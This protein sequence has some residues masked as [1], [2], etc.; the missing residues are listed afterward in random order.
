MAGRRFNM[1]DDDV[2][3]VENG[4][5]G[6]VEDEL[7]GGVADVINEVGM[8]DEVDGGMEES[9][10]SGSDSEDSVRSEMILFGDPDEDVLTDSEPIANEDVET[11]I[12]V[13]ISRR[14]GGGGASV[15][16]V[17]EV[18]GED[19]SVLG[20]GEV[21]GAGNVH[22]MGGDECNDGDVDSNYAPSDEL[23]SLPSD[24]DDEFPRKRELI[25]NRDRDL[26]NPKLVVGTKFA[27]PVDFRELLRRFSVMKGFDL[28]FKKNFGQKITATCKEECG[29]RI[30]SSWTIDKKFF[31]IKTFQPKHQCSR[32]YKNNQASSTWLANY[33]LEKIRDNLDW[34]LKAMRVTIKRELELDVSK[35]KVYRTKREALQMIEGKHLEQYNRLWDYCH[36]IRTTNPCSYVQ[37]KVERFHLSMPAAFQRLFISFVA[38]INGFKAGCRLFIGLDGCFL[39][40]CYGGQLLSAVGRDGNNQMFPL[41]MAVVEAEIKHSWHWFMTNL[42]QALDCQDYTGI[43]FISDRQKGLVDTFAVL[44]PGADHRHCVRHMYANFKEKHKEQDLKDML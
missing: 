11:L 39:K 21:G 6:A 3:N 30:H 26:D 23:I 32:N 29:W 34:K 13:A 42:L 22:N 41:A 9:S 36:A 7:D 27:T 38:Q 10:E 18:D 5:V 25:Y 19:D 16:G 37:M 43:T 44:L 40:G 12:D 24:S 1:V 2:F 15:F 31:Q 4:L 17:G 33:Y 14:V 35:T 8:E 20:V 28:K